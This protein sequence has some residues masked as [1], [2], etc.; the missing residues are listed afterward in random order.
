[1]GGW[2]GQTTCPDGPGNVGPGDAGGTACPANGVGYAGETG[3]FYPDPKRSERV[4]QTLKHVVCR[5]HSTQSRN[6]K[7]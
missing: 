3:A 2:T 5:L 4:I 1:M 7:I 6:A